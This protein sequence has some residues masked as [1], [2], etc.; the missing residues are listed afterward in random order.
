M[1]R[2]MRDTGAFKKTPV[3]ILQMTLEGLLTQP[4]LMRKT[5]D[6]IED[7]CLDILREGKDT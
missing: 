3:I 1:V 7:V 2:Q 6:M 4:E 5:A